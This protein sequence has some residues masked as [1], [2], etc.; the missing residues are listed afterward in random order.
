MHEFATLMTEIVMMA[1]KIDGKTLI[2]ASLIA[3]TKGEYF[4]L[5]PDAFNRFSLSDGTIN[6][7]MKSETT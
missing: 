2:P 7:T 6:P 1:L 3:T 5:A 4:E